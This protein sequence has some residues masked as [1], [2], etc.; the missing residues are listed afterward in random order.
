LHDVEFN[1]EGYPS[2]EWHVDFSGREL[3]LIEAFIEEPKE[4]S[5]TIAEKIHSARSF[6]LAQRKA[7]G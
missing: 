1:V 7:H 5:E 6:R 2:E 4:F 3:D